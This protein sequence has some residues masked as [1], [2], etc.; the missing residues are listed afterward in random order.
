MFAILIML[1]FSIIPHP[2]HAADPMIEPNGCGSGWSTNFVP[3]S[4]SLLK[5][6]F[7]SACDAHD[8]CYGACLKGGANE[9][10]PECEY[11]RCRK[12]GNL[13][14]KPECE[15]A[16][17]IRLLASAN[18]RRKSCDK[19]LAEDIISANVGKPACAAFA[20]IYRD[21]VRN[22]GASNFIGIEGSIS[23]ITQSPKDY[24]FA[25]DEFFRLGSEGDFVNFIM[26]QNTPN[27]AINFKCNIYY[28][29]DR[30]LINDVKCE[31]KQ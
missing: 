15:N 21:A 26:A 20:I 1:E 24:Y 5:C 31:D 10:K 19:A 14:G 22:F 23:H 3:D 11:L 9:G 28:K 8:I 30:G 17:F 18:V 13:A 4:I 7:K 27:R 16:K 2:T 12:G 25:I 29:N 6:N